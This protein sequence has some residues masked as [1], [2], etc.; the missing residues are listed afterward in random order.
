MTQ[1]L[2]VRRTASTDADLIRHLRI[3]SLTGI[4]YAFG[5]GLEEVLAQPHDAF[6]KTAPVGPFYPAPPQSVAEW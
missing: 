4:P 1:A 5:T 3:A 6:Q 2:T